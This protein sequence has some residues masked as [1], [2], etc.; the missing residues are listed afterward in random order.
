[1]VKTGIMPPAVLLVEFNGRELRLS[2]CRERGIS[3]WSA[4]KRRGRFYKVR[5]ITV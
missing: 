2:D 5:I 3:V 4:D 1:M